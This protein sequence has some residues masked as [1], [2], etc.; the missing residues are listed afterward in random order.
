MR[1]GGNE[2]LQQYREEQEIVAHFLRP[3]YKKISQSDLKVEDIYRFY[4]RNNS[5][6]CC[7]NRAAS[8]QAPQRLFQNCREYLEPEIALLAPDIR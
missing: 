6:K 1:P 8:R 4:A 2:R 5:I 7:A 3:F